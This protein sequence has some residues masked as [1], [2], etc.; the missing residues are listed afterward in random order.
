[1]NYKLLIP[2]SILALVFIAL[3]G[4][5][6][7]E[8]ATTITITITSTSFLAPGGFSENYW[9]IPM[10]LI[11]GVMMIFFGTAIA[12]DSSQLVTMTFIGLICGLSIAYYAQMVNL[13]FIILAMIAFGFYAWKGMQA[14]QQVG[15]KYF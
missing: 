5:N 4:L 2:V 14:G 9:L 10:A 3:T 1:M 7:V 8:A 12:I 11:G 15:E 6:K 13:G